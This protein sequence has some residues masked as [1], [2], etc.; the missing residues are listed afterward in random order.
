ML[1]KETEMPLTTIEIQS[2]SQSLEDLV[3]KA[4]EYYFPAGVKSAWVF[5]PALKA[6][7]IILPGDQNFLFISGEANDPTNGIRIPVEK[8]FEGID[9]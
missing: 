1:A 4:W 5:I 6:V 2:P 3:A 9:L 8:I 7:R